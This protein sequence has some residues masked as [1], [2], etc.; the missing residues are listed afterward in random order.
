MTSVTFNLAKSAG[1]V[2]LCLTPN[3]TSASITPISTVSTVSPFKNIDRLIPASPVPTGISEICL[4][5]DQLL[6]PYQDY[7]SVAFLDTS[8]TLENIPGFYILAKPKTHEWILIRDSD[9]SAPCLVDTGTAMDYVTNIDTVSVAPHFIQPENMICTNMI[10]DNM[11]EAAQTGH[12][13][14]L[15]AVTQ[16]KK[17]FFLTTND[18]GAWNILVY[19]GANQ[20]NCTLSFVGGYQSAFNQNTIEDI[21]NNS[22]TLDVRACYDGPVMS[23]PIPNTPPKFGNYFKKAAIY[24]A[25]NGCPEHRI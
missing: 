5:W 20:T 17:D 6:Q 19:D 13:I 22:Q 4:N 10:A 8:E 18:D 2:A 16:S 12:Q 15:H 25:A 14:A 21:F 11:S 9:K 7:Q 23:V 1:V 24:V 3:F